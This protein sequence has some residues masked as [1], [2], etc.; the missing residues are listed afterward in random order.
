MVD[1]LVA[2]Y[3][4]VIV[5]EC[6]G[7][8]AVEF[9]QVLRQVKA[10]YV[11]GLTATPVRYDGHHPVITMQC[12]PIRYRVRHRDVDTRIAEHITLPRYT[13]SRLPEHAEHYKTQEIISELVK[14]EHRNQMIIEDVLQAVAEKRTPLVLTKRKDHLR[15]LQEKLEGK[16]K[17]ILVYHGGI[18]LKKLNALRTQLE[19]VPE[20]EERIVL[21]IGQCLGQGF[22]DSRLD[23]LFLALPISFHGTLEQYAGRLHRAHH[24]KSVVKIYDYVDA[25]IEKMYRMFRTRQKGYKH[26]GYT[27][28]TSLQSDT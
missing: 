25:N 12:G 10:K 2:Q 26:I 17:N 16:V 15:L 5:D 11:V 27:I 8:G 21:A 14:D 3:G 7:A 24:G 9:E 6:H 28:Q 19:A 22:D 1:D 13:K 4:Q 20:N 23:T 18:S